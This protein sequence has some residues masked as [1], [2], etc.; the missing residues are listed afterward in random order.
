MKLLIAIFYLY[1]CSIYVPRQYVWRIWR[2]IYFY[3]ST[4]STKTRSSILKGFYDHHCSLSVSTRLIR[5][6]HWN[7]CFLYPKFQ[8]PC[9]YIRT[10]LST[11]LFRLATLR[12]ISKKSINV[13]L[14]FM[15]KLPFKCYITVSC[16]TIISISE[17]IFLP[18]KIEFKDSR[19]V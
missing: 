17:L 18:H 3:L 16:R 13:D 12:E 9:Q 8:D 1:W 15:L 4:S 6:Y 10:L 11:V 19:L 5:P 2:Y 7:W 14:T